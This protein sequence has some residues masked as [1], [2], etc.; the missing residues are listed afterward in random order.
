MAIGKPG[1]T[2]DVKMKEKKNVK[3]EEGPK[4][5]LDDSV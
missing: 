4:S 3:K 2:I 5:R 1:G